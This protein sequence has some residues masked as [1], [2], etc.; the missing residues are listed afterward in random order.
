MRSHRDE[1]SCDRCRYLPYLPY[2][3]YLLRACGAFADA[4]HACAMRV[5]HTCR[6]HH[7]WQRAHPSRHPPPC[8]DW[9]LYFFNTNRVRERCQLGHATVSGLDFTLGRFVKPAESAAYMGKGC[10]LHGWRPYWKPPTAHGAS[11][12]HGAVN[13]VCNATRIPGY[14]TM[15]PGVPAHPVK[16]ICGGVATVPTDDDTAMLRGATSSTSGGG[17]GGASS[18]S[19]SSKGLERAE[20]KVQR[21]GGDGATGG[22]ARVATGGGARVANAKR[23]GG[24]GA[25]GVGARVANANLT[26]GTRRGLLRGGGG[27]AGAA[28]VDAPPEGL[29]GTKAKPA[30]EALKELSQLR[31][32]KLISAGEWESAK[33]RLIDAVVSRGIAAL[34]TTATNAK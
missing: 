8:S 5:R 10:R 20:R 12:S 13:G 4:C 15:C 2:L 27:A 23:T 17:G 16:R 31:D 32:E 9:G 14:M 24:D 33:A 30:R 11:T 28:S 18:S 1:P 25:A 7:K 21:T 34:P 26:R 3:P 29:R 6:A 19:S 22:G